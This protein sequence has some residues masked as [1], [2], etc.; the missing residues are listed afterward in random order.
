MLRIDLIACVVTL[1]WPYANLPAASEAPAP[2]DPAKLVWRDAPPAYM[3]VVTAVSGE[4]ITIKPAGDLKVTRSRFVNGKSEVVKVYVQ[5]NTEAPRTFVFGDVVLWH[6]GTLPATKRAGKPPLGVSN[7][8]GQHKI[9]D[10]RVGDFVHI[11]CGPVEG[12][13]HCSEIQIRRRP[14][15]QV[16]PTMGE[17]KL[18]AGLRISIQF[19]AAQAKEEKI[20]RIVLRTIRLRP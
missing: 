18:P 3:G 2:I 4:T 17:D 13:D 16:P 12:V 1:L 9:S 15:G 20:M 19:N 14:G 11:S 10:V 8:L 6:S 7:P 5:D